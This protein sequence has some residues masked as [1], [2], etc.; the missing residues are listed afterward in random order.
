MDDERAPERGTQMPAISS[1]ERSLQ[2]VRPA[3]VCQ[4]LG[5]IHR[6]TLW[7]W[8]RSGR[9]PKPIALS[10]SVIG[11][12]ERDVEDWL[13]TRAAASSPGEASDEGHSRP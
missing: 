10:R 8:C 3:K 13:D 6:A 2:I 11:W 9:F 1:T 4:L 12:R 7:R 5:G